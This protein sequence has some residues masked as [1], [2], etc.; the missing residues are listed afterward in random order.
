MQTHL[1]GRLWHLVWRADSDLREQTLLQYSATVPLTQEA[2]IAGGVVALLTLLL[3]EG[4]M[5]LGRRLNSTVT[6]L[7]NHRYRGA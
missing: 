1:V 7:I 5:A 6:R 2:V 3:L 4:A